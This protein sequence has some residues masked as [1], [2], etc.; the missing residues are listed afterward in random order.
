M[1]TLLALPARFPVILLLLVG[2]LAIP[3][4]SPRPVA[5]STTARPSADRPGEPWQTGEPVPGPAS[6]GTDLGTPSLRV[7]ESWRDYGKAPDLF[8][9]M[10]Q[11]PGRYFNLEPEALGEIV[12]TALTENPEI[13]E[14]EAAWR[15]G[16]KR[17][18]VVSS[19]PDPMLSV[20]AFLLNVET[21]VG[22][23]EAVLGA[24]QRLPW[25]GKLSAAGQAA[26]EEALAKA[27]AWLALQRNVVLDVKRSYYLLAYL[28]EALR[29]TDEDLSTLKRYEDISLTR[30]STGRG[31]QQNVVKVQSETTRLRE[32][33]I[34]LLRQ[35]DFARRELARLVGRPL[36][37][38]EFHFTK[39][40][41]PIVTVDLDDL[42]E[43]VSENREEFQSRWHEVRARRQGI[44]LAKKQYWPDLTVGFN[45]II[46]GDR[47]DAMG[48]SSPPEDNGQDAA[49]VLASINLPI[50][51][52]R[53][54]AGVDEA[55][56]KEYEARA[57]YA[58]QED[59]VL[60]E[61]QDAYIRLTSLREQLDLYRH[62][63]IPQADQALQSSEAAYG[64]GKVTFL[65]L[66]DSERFLLSARYGF[67]RIKSDYLTALAQMERALAAPFPPTDEAAA[68]HALPTN[69]STKG[70]IP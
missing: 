22:P 62:A 41:L 60:S 2:C 26:F 55:R 45:Y 40:D 58:R 1:R 21:R 19:L 34:V 63:L 8:P 59:R 37:P 52:P 68:A 57:A 30:Y 33:R 5:A 3:F 35:R 66:L 9:G 48:T 16:L 53:L 24:S 46:V 67:A 56:L 4:G 42:Y 12:R 29:I 54:K 38:F 18:R 20:T 27:W 23:Q 17:A 61:L 25:F 13:R 31:I 6:V 36:D 7:D 65:E 28:D 70:R 10:A 32:R 69:R 44:R 51:F 64:T 43:E 14:A 39:E 47:Q 49:G 15:A 50:W 11:E